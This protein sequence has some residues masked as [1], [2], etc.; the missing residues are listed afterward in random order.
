MRVPIIAGPL[1]AALRADLL[2]TAQTYARKATRQE[3]L[4]G[5]GVRG[6][7]SSGS[8]GVKLSVSTLKYMLSGAHLHLVCVTAFI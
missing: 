3:A 7:R 1:P 8:G 2:L 5:H 6:K 4:G